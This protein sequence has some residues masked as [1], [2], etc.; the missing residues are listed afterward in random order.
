MEKDTL[1]RVKGGAV[2][3]PAGAPLSTGIVLMA[4]REGI[5]VW[6]TPGTIIIYTAGCTCGDGGSGAPRR[7]QHLFPHFVS[8]RERKVLSVG[9]VDSA[10]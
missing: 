1:L 4:T 10:F 2:N 5:C 3:S 7:N 9:T 6:V 8:E